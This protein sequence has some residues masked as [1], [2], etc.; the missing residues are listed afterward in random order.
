MFAWA[1]RLV[2]KLVRMLALTSG[3][4]WVFAS[5]S[6]WVGTWAAAWAARWAR[7]RVG[8]Y[9]LSGQTFPSAAAMAQARAAASEPDLGS[10]WALALASETGPGWVLR[11]VLQTALTKAQAS[12]HSWVPHSVLE[13]VLESALASE[14]PWALRL[15]LRTALT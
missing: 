12:G 5:V 1:P 3:Q 9:P 4:P 10:V 15:E 2:P 6:A 11:L 14:L 8:R 13:T 7:S